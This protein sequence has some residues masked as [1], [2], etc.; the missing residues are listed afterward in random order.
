MVRDPP[1][2]RWFRKYQRLSVTIRM[3]WYCTKEVEVLDVSTMRIIE[4]ARELDI[5][6]FGE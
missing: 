1:S 4:S 3:G 5:P 6:E 2:T